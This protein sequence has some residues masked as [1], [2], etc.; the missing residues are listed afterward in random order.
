MIERITEFVSKLNERFGG[1]QY[2]GDQSPV[3]FT[4]SEGKKYFKVWK[5]SNQQCIYCFV[6]Q[7]GNIYMPAGCK[8]PAKGVRGTIDK[9]FE[10]CCYKHGVRYN[11]GYVNY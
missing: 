4:F 1:A 7:E 6:D 11:K 10:N 2:E 9:P 3:K 8:A 5:H